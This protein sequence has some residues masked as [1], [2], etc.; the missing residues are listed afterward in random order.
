[1]QDST[2]HGLSCTSR[3]ALAGARCSSMGIDPTIHRTMNERSYHGVT[4]RSRSL[5]TLGNQSHFRTFIF[6]DALDTLLLTAI[7]EIFTRESNPYSDTLTRIDQ[8]MIAHQ[9]DA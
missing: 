5:D 9:A 8:I 6:N 7:S 4:Y 2:Y 3:K 1:M